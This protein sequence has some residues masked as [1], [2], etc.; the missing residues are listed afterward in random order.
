[1]NVSHARACKHACKMHAFRPDECTM[2]A[3]RPEYALGS[4][5][6]YY[7]LFI[8]IIIIVYCRYVVIVDK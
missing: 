4:T 5:S 6:A 2:H 8:S 7:V 1:M 3:F